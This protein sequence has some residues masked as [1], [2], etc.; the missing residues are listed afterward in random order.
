MHYL[1]SALQLH[2]VSSGEVFS[3][4]EN[5]FSLTPKQKGEVDNCIWNS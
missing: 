5:L 2:E 4:L 3:S 1:D